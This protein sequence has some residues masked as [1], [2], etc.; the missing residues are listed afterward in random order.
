MA[1]LTLFEK[2]GQIETRYDEMTRELSSAEVLRDSGALPEARASTHA[3]LSEI[4]EKY[5]EWKRS[6]RTCTGRKQMSWKAKT[7][8]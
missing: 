6:K 7:P 4:V 3:E 2:L 1:N 5:R 8:R